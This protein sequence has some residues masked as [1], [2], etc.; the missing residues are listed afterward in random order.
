M[1]LQSQKQWINNSDLKI[2]KKDKK[3]EKLEWRT[4]R[5]D[6]IS[7]IFFQHKDTSRWYY[8]TITSK[9]TLALISDITSKRKHF[10]SCI[11]IVF[12]CFLV[13]LFKNT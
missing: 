12:A 7:L 5:A 10:S 3:T 8:F 4:L 1:Q 13:L 2:L 9:F 11:Y 6:N